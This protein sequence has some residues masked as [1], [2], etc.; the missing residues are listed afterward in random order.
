MDDIDAAVE[1]AEYVRAMRDVV[2]HPTKDWEWMAA[3]ELEKYI[4]QNKSKNPKAY[5]L[6]TIVESTLGLYLVHTNVF[7]FCFEHYT[8]INADII[9]LQFL[10]FAKDNGSNALCNF[11][12]T[13]ASFKQVSSDCAN[14]SRVCNNQRRSYV[15]QATE[16]SLL[17]EARH[18]V[19][20]YLVD[21]S[22]GVNDY[23]AAEWPARVSTSSE[24]H[25][26][27]EPAGSLTRGGSNAIKIS[28]DRVARLVAAF[29]ERK[30][31][32]SMI[33]PLSSHRMS[34]PSPSSSQRKPSTLILSPD[35]SMFDTIESAVFEMLKETHWSAFMESEE[36]TRYHQFMAMQGQ[37]EKDGM[38]ENVDFFVLRVVGRGGFGQVL[39]RT[40]VLHS[41][42]TFTYSSISQHMHNR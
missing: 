16:Y 41:I 12:L 29:S 35:K 32:L 8:I 9:S 22:K 13:I 10:K 2:P 39:R 34:S 37:I 18:I 30:S 42:F 14:K 4:E 26:F 36:W 27:D 23:F 15:R 1:D 33:S 38:Q 17:S 11:V 24:S 21:G 19:Q 28:G 25:P 6:E 40:S 3:P 20:E 7:N 5:R 31:S